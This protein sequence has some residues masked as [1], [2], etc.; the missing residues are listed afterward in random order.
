[1][2]ISKS[3]NPEGREKKYEKVLVEIYEHSNIYIK[4]KDGKT[5]V[6]KLIQAHYIR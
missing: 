3:I 6:S 2:I 4:N 1:M 5:I